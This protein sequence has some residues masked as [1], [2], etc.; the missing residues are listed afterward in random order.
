MPGS[1]DCIVNT[2]TGKIQGGFENGLYVFK[3]IPYAAPPVG[4]LRWMPPQPPLPWD[5]VRPALQFGTIAS[6]PSMPSIPGREREDEPQSEDCL[7]LN[8]WTPGLDDARRPVMV[9]IHGGAFS[10]GSGSEVM[11]RGGRLSAFGN[12]V[13]VTLNYRL[14]VFGFL[15]L[16]ELTQGKIPSTGNEGLLDQTAALT[17]VRDN[18]ASF[19]GDP[20]NV[21]IFGE[22]AGAMSVACL[23]NLP[24]AQGLFH[25]A[26]LQSAV[27]EIAR[28]LA[29]SVEIAAEFLNIVDIRADDTDSLRAIPVEKLLSAQLLVAAK[30]GQGMAPAIPVAD[31]R[32]LPEMP[33]KAFDSGLAAGVPTLVG[34]NLD[35]QKLFSIMHPETMN[36]T[37][38]DLENIARAYVPSGDP[39][40]LLRVYRSARE[41]R[42]DSTAPFEIFSAM[43]TDLLFRRVALRIAEAQCKYAPPA[44]N[45]LFTWKSP[46]AGGA[47]GACHALEIG[48][49]FGTHNDLFCGSGPEADKLSH[50]LQ[51][52]WVSFAR[53]GNP[54]CASLGDW[55]PYCADRSTMILDKDC[56]VVQAAFEEERRVWDEIGPVKMDKML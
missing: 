47:L 49:I 41:K 53:T 27:G 28:P 38:A 30:T 5:G 1:A 21:T 37:E 22:S 23:M 2:R 34:S 42:G 45:Y 7:F 25:K 12:I 51:D 26:I 36:M 33:L 24:S 10:I 52:A 20:G 55:P 4:P 3:G 6:Q 9:W 11:F 50:C 35:E 13:L 17:W 16:N 40:R 44:Y 48:F 29:P 32:I 43:N 46:A 8:V 56:R 18:I 15:N 54:S 19:G 39:D 14:G 31:G